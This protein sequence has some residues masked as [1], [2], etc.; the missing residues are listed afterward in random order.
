M[1]IL[2]GCDYISNIPGVGIGRARKFFESLIENPTAE[3]IHKILEKLP[4]VLNMNG[5]V[6]VTN[7]YIEEFIRASNTFNHQIVYSPQFDQLVYLNPLTKN[8]DPK[9]LEQ[10]GGNFFPN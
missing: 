4:T 7:D 8:V 5:K 9:E 3:N 10:Y 1:C 2:S 6:K